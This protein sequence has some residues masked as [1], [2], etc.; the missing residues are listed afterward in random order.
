MRTHYCRHQAQKFSP[1][2]VVEPFYGGRA[3]SRKKAEEEATPHCRF[4]ESA[5]QKEAD[6][7]EAENAAEARGVAVVKAAKVAEAA[8]ADNAR[9]VAAAAEAEEAVKKAEV[10]RVGALEKAAQ[11]KKK[12]GGWS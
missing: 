7:E 3:K 8:D 4:V 1:G 11:L 10:A 2:F 9:K 12:E 5:E 6:A